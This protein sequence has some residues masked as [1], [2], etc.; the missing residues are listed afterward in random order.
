MNS[1]NKTGLV[2]VTI[3]ILLLFLFFPDV[4][5][6][7]NT[8]MFSIEGDGA[9]NYFSVLYY[10]QNNT[11]IHFT[12][13][14]YPNGEH[15]SFADGQPGLIIPFHYLSLL[16]PFLK[17]YGVALINLSVLLSFAAGVWFTYKILVFYR[18]QHLFSV[19]GALLILFLSPQLLRLQA[20]YALSYAC[21]FPMTW[22]F[23]I[24][25]NNSKNVIGWSI[26][27]IV[28]LVFFGLVHFY[29][30][31]ISVM[32][33]FCFA[34]LKILFQYKKISFLKHL[35]NWLVPVAIL[36]ILQLFIFLTDHITDRP[37]RPWGFFYAIADW[38]TIFLPHPTDLFGNPNLI[39]PGFGEGFAY[40]GLVP[41]IA[42]LFIVIRFFWNSF[43]L[44]LKKIKKDLNSDNSLY[45]LSAIPLLLFSMCIPFIWGLENIVNY[46]PFIRQFRVPGRFAWVFYYTTGVQAVLFFYTVYRMNV[47]HKLKR[48]ANILI[49][50]TAFIWTAEMIVRVN[51]V[52][53]RFGSVLSNYKEFND[54]SFVRQLGE[55]GYYTSDFQAILSFPFFHQGSEQF[56]IE[57]GPSQLN[58]LKASWQLKIP[59]INVMMSRTSLQQSCDVVQLLSD[60]L[61]EKKMLARLKPKPLLLITHG[62]DFSLNEQILISKA[63]LLKENTD[64]KIYLL[65]VNVFDANQNT[66]IQI[67]NH[68]QSKLKNHNDYWSSMDSSTAYFNYFSNNTKPLSTFISNAENKVLFENKLQGIKMNDTM[69]LSLWVKVDPFIESLPFI[70]YEN[71]SNTGSIQQSENFS[72]KTQTNVYEGCVLLKQQIIIKNPD[73]LLSIRIT[74]RCLFANL[75]IRNKREDV[76]LEIPGFG[77]YVNNIPVKSK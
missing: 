53:K 33:L 4:M 11:G 16:F 77:F 12:G 21:F 72:F 29:L 76:Y 28:S 5:L 58:A 31:V 40:I 61:I 13:M 3:A 71:R 55:A 18:V 36:L 34:L 48:T 46:F 69:E 41:L 38:K 51:E 6:H 7:P 9:K 17:N 74:G 8:S 35:T 25:M 14:N 37:P 47:Q 62:S 57:H 32:F 54:N 19:V 42:F 70:H 43:L 49:V 23:S 22:Y 2:A 52:N 60:S 39:L 65:P 56:S 20:H 75:L 73:D 67:F 68:R 26:I 27:T 66:V 45:F 50:G 1:E 63:T 59:M 30:A 24:R 15:L 64:S 10:L 44:R